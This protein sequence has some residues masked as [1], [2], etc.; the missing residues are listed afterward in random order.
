VLAG[1]GSPYLYEIIFY[2]IHTSHTMS[3]DMRGD[4][5][6]GLWKFFGKLLRWLRKSNLDRKLLS[7]SYYIDKR[8]HI[9]HRSI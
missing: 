8:V 1:E 4:R 9:L 3:E 7:G 5:T 6:E 2:T